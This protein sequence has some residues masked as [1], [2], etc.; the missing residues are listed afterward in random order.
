MKLL[1]AA[2]LYVTSDLHKEFVD[3]TLDSIR[4]KHEYKVALIRNNVNDYFNPKVRFYNNHKNCVAGAWNMAIKMAAEEGFD[5]VL[6]PNLDIVFRED[7][8]D[9]LIEFAEK[10]SEAVLWTASSH[11]DLRT[12]NTVETTDDVG[13]SPH[14]SC[15]MVRGSFSRDW[16]EDD[17]DQTGL[18]DE[19][20]EPA[21]FEDLDMH[22][23]IRKAGKKALRTT[24]AL[25]YHYGSRTIH[26][27]EDPM[28]AEATLGSTATR[29]YYMAKWGSTEFDKI[30]DRPFNR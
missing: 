15:F 27:S 24:S 30:Y 22:N 4:T 14:F 20:F 26:A 9:K 13:E 28:V 1:I 5:W 21:Y 17:P 12:L 25:F 19:G 16:R 23:R 6:L 10:E 11:E 7:C 3:Q 8:I 29:P 2:P 18:F